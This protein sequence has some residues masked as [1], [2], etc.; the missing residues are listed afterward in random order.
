MISEAGWRSVAT[1]IL[2]TILFGFA[3]AIGFVPEV[4]LSGYYQQT[5]IAAFSP[6][7]A[8]TA[9]MMAL[10]VNRRR[11]D[12]AP[13][14]FGIAGL[15]FLAFAIGREGHAWD[16]SWAHESKQQYLLHAFFGTEQQ[17]SSSECLSELFCTTPC[18][19]AVAYS[20]G[21]ALAIFLPAWAHP[22]EG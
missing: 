20:L 3:L 14:L 4:L 12:R 8:T 6:C 2:H 15:L 19:A 13:L 1:F 11:K 17:C 22:H 10:L 16:P 21:G 18:T 5:H 7:I 9:F